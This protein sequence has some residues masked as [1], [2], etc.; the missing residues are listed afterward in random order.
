MFLYCT[1]AR[2]ILGGGKRLGRQ[3]VE[4]IR[5][6]IVR[7]C[8]GPSV[9]EGNILCQ[10]A[11]DL[12][13]INKFEQDCHAKMPR[14]PDASK[15]DTVEEVAASNMVFL[16]TMR[17]LAAAPVLTVSKGK[18][19]SLVHGAREQ[20][21]KLL[22]TWCSLWLEEVVEGGNGLPT[23]VPAVIV[24]GQGF[25]GIETKR[26]KELREKKEAEENE[27]ARLKKERLEKE[28]IELE[29]KAAEAKKQEEIKKEKE[30]RTKQSE[31]DEA[32]RKTKWEDIWATYEE[33]EDTRD[34]ALKNKK[35]GMGTNKWGWA[36][37]K[38]SQTTMKPLEEVKVHTHVLA[39]IVPPAYL[40]HTFT[41][42][43]RRKKMC[44]LLTLSFWT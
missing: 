11:D 15:G 23:K 38:L 40:Q 9:E 4:N 18:A 30:A 32:A 39:A 20:L 22:E 26:G 13:F 19:E 7:L 29:R 21:A 3:D 17:V 16:G 44:L 10:A 8:D 14:Q 25:K 43:R 35:E 28:R 24:S 12:A 27:E 1:W 33:A 34:K 37:V 5:D 31:V 6:V 2:F 36:V 42:R 41:H